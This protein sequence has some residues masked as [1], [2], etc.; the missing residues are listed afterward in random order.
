MSGLYYCWVCYL[1]VEP[2]VCLTLCFDCALQLNTQM[3]NG[4]E[5]SFSDLFVVL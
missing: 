4:D 5:V 2:V 1:T 3:D